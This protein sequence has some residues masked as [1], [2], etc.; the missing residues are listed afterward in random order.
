[1][2]TFHSSAPLGTGKKSSAAYQRHEP[3]KTVLYK[4]VSEHLETFLGE[5]R[6]HYDKPLPKYVEKELRDYLKCGLLQYGFAKAV[7]KEC[8]RTILVAFS[9]KKRGACCSCSARRMCNGAAHLVDHVTPRC[10]CSSMGIERAFRIE[11]FVGLSC[12][13]LWCHDQPVHQ[14][15]ISLATRAST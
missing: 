13:C 4:I 15:G 6:D 8:G 10:A 9:C 11:T 7:C 1:M 5:V 2:G 14:R 12:G 3:E